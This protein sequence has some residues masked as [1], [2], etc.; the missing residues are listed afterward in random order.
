[1]VIQ[2][3]GGEC[4]RPCGHRTGKYS[5]KIKFIKSRIDTGSITESRM[6]EF[7]ETIQSIRS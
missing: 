5:M 2:G 7:L 6:S 4:W 3:S 1:M